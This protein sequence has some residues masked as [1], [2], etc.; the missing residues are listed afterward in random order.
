MQKLFNNILVPLSINRKADVAI[1]KAI[2]FANHLQCNLH[3]IGIPSVPSLVQGKQRIF[4]NRNGTQ[5][6]AEKKCKL[7]ELQTKYCQQLDKGLMLSISFEKGEPEAII[8]TYAALHQIDLVLVVGER[9]KFPF[10]QQVINANRLAG[11]TNCPVLTLKADPVLD[12]LKIIVMPVG[13]SLPINKIRV[14]AYLAKHYD[15]SIHLITREKNLLM[16]EELA[17]MQKALQ[18]LKDNTNLP[19]KCKTLVG[20]SIGNIALQYANEVKAGLILVNP[21]T[22]SFLPGLLN[23]LFSR[24]VF[25]ESNIPVMTVV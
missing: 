25:N 5:D 16:Y 19:V 1:E 15:A 10:L 8:S 23:R 17:Y 11:K 21:G 4:L 2:Q 9:K 13:K 6:V 20:E 7:A 18:V 14:A 24:F 12:G 3:L 22:E